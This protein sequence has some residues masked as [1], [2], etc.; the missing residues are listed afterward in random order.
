MIGSHS[1]IE[2]PEPVMRVSP[3]M[4]TMAR[5]MTAMAR[6]HTPTALRDACIE[7]PIQIARS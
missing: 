2:R 3:P 1:V 6:S 5:M 7:V 4:V